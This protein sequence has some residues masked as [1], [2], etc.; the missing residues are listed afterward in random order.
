MPH[1]K[2]NFWRLAIVFAGLT[3]VTLILL[4]SLPQ[5][6]KSEMMSNSMG[7]MMKEMQEK[8]LTIYDLF[9]AAEEQT[10]GNQDEQVQAD[11]TQSHHAPTSI[12][13]TFNFLSTAIIFLFL[14]LIIGGAIVLAIAWIR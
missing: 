8:N 13:V 4:W 11:D 6:P 9:D 10:Q 3:A 12:M 2:L 7:N 5:Q 1:K 14:P